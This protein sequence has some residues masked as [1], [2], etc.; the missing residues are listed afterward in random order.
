MMKRKHNEKPAMAQEEEGEHPPHH[1]GS[2][3]KA[4]GEAKSDGVI[5]LEASMTSSI[6]VRLVGEHDHIKTRDG[7]IRCTDFSTVKVPFPWRL[8]QLLEDSEKN[9]N[10]SI[11]SWLLDGDG[12]SISKPDLFTDSIMKSYFALTTY[13]SFVQEVRGAPNLGY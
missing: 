1:D 13:D 4:Q 10:Q 3:T 6:R 8:W 2:S 7:K 12:F 11:V 5:M 9:G